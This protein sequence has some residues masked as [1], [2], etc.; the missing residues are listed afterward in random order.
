M[1]PLRRNLTFSFAY[2]TNFPAA[3]PI[4][5]RKPSHHVYADGGSTV[6]LCCE[7][8]GHVVWSRSG[9]TLPSLL[10]FIQKDGCLT[11]RNMNG[12]RA[13]EYTCRATNQFG[14]SE[15]TS[16]VILTGEVIL[17][18]FLFSFIYIYFLFIYLFVSHSHNITLNALNQIYTLCC[19]LMRQGNLEYRVYR[20]LHQT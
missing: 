2:H 6:K 5:T 9:A 19:E 8:D 20:R 14:K 13:G 10:Y 15:A 3:S 12:E 1:S 17:Y 16:E 18:V 4:L 11:I 7:A